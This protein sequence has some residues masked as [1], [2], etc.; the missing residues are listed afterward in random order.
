MLPKLWSL[1]YGT[2]LG[3]C[4]FTASST[5]SSFW[6]THIAHLFGLAGVE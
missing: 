3:H 6:I 1:T 2:S 4:H 5:S